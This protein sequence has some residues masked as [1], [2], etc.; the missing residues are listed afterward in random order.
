MRDRTLLKQF[1]DEVKA[2]NH[3][4]ILAGFDEAGRGPLCGP[5]VAA[6]VVLPGDFYCPYIDDSKKLTP[7]EREKASLIIKEK[8]LAYAIC[9]ISP[10]EID[11]I[12]ILEASR[13]GMENCLKELEKKIK[14]EY[15][16]TDYMKLSTSLPVLAIAKGDA[17]SESVAAASILAKTARDSYMV[18]MGEKFPEY[19]FEKHKGYPT[20]HH[21][22]LL[23]Q[24]GVIKSFYRMTYKP[25]SIA[26][27]KSGF[28][29]KYL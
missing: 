24:Y 22:E 15:C 19:E 17:T 21:L 5:V 7:K 27:R 11:Q 14:V 13:K 2:K 20:K 8:A 9:F 4:Q 1:D 10:S 29:K 6:G 28:N 16:I 12:N 3:C 25:V 26:V 18:E 23:N